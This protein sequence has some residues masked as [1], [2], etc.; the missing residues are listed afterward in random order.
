MFKIDNTQISKRNNN[1]INFKGTN[2]LTNTA[3][4]ADV[5][6]KS[7]ENLSSTRFIQDTA[8]NWLPKAVV[9]RSKEDF[10]EMSFLEF[11]ESGIFY[12]ALPIFGEK[13]FRNGIFKN[14]IPKNIKETVNEQLPKTIKEITTNKNLSNDVKNSAI[15]TKAGI[16][17]ACTLIPVAEY[18]LSFAKNYFTLKTFNKSNFDNIANLDKN[19]E[20]KED[21]AQ[22]EKVEKN[23]IKHFKLA[24]AISA[25]GIG[26][27]LLLATKGKNSKIGQNISK[28]VLEPTKTLNNFLINKGL[29]KKDSFK[30]LNSISLDFANNKGKLALSKGQLGL[31][32]IIGL[33]G[34]S[35]AAEDRGTLD[36]KEV[37]TRVPLVVFYTIFG[38]ELFEKAFS[39]ILSKKNAFPDLIKKGTDGKTI[40]PTRDELPKIAQTLAKK[41]KTAPNIE[42]S[43]LTKQKAFISAVPYAFSLL[44]MG[45]SLSLLTR[46]FTQYRYNKEHKD[47]NKTATGLV[48]GKN[49]ADFE[50][51]VKQNN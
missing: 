26:T 41:N 9:S 13:L 22:Q 35:K 50:N 27:G 1:H 25:L 21:K 33:F 42:L 29:K 31:T 11:L 20:T 49:V 8:T 4:I 16:L 39:K 5:F 47:E 40:I 43:K 37:W 46:I 17:L 2:A 32:A 44:F 6:L 34:Y 38:S 30:F 36:K 48:F 24:G 19:H 12:F 10:A 23:A 45:F 28:A 18:T 14:L 15:A 51:F 3:K 7:Q